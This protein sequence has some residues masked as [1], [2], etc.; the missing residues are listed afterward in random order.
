[1]RTG[2]ARTRLHVAYGQYCLMNAVGDLPKA[3][4]AGTRLVEAQGETAFVLCGIH[5]GSIELTARTHDGAVPVDL[6]SRDD[7]VEVGLP[8][9]DGRL[10][11]AG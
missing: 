1:M 7:V 2:E 5:T 6:G 8:C 10:V 4:T 9:P 3:S 11:V